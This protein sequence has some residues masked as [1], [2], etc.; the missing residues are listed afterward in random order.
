VTAICLL[1]ACQALAQSERF[2]APESEIERLELDYWQALKDGDL[3]EWATLF[4]SEFRCGYPPLRAE[5]L[6]KEANMESLEVLAEAMDEIVSMISPGTFDYEIRRHIIRVEEKYAFSNY[7]LAWWASLPDGGLIGGRAGILHKWVRT[8]DRWLLITS[9]GEPLEWES[10]GE[11]VD[12]DWIAV[13]VPTK[14]RVVSDNGSV[15]AVFDRSK[16]IDVLVKASKEYMWV[17]GEM[18]YFDGE[19]RVVLNRISGIHPNWLQS[20]TA[21]LLPILK[22]V[23]DRGNIQI[24]A[25]LRLVESD[26]WVRDELPDVEK[27]P[28]HRLWTGYATGILE[29]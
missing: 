18:F 29:D 1:V 15:S 13:S 21:F 26:D 27:A 20:P 23:L 19:E 4:H 8:P 6:G 9:V 5:A 7:K 2:S 28:Q 14:L 12:A 11:R 16:F 3:I 25:E 24:I 17:E 10:L 22:P